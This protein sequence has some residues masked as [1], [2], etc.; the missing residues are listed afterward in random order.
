MHIL[1]KKVF[2]KKIIWLTIFLCSC[3]LLK[4]QGLGCTDV[5]AN[6]YDKA[7]TV[8]NGSCTYDNVAIKPIFNNNL[9]KTVDETSG[10]LYWNKQVW[11]HNDSGGKPD[12][13]VVDDST[14]KAIKTVTITNAAN[15]DWEDVT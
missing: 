4:A 2:I 15:V 6:N 5:A 10:L 8:N 3:S 1:I 13:Y 7:A 11:T 14:G 12:L 9:D